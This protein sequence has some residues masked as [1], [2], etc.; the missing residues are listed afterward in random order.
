MKFA[1]F[2]FTFFALLLAV[3]ALPS[4]I[5][6]QNNAVQARD[7]TSNQ[8][9][10]ERLVEEDDPIFARYFGSTYEISERDYAAA[11]VEPRAIGMVVT[12]VKDVVEGVMSIVNL[13]KG[14]IE[15]DKSMRGQWTGTM[16]GQFRQKYPQFNFV[17]CH[18]EHKFSP[19]P[20]TVSGHQHQELNVSFGKTIGY[21]I[22]W[23]K[24]GTFQRIGD[25]GWLNWSYAG[26]VKRTSDGGKFLEFGP[27]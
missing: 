6:P 1:T 14:K 3:A 18:T 24:E 10:D 16:I 25:G 8:E 9:L 12:V 7:V 15:Q 21:E 2:L 4:P 20:G 5:H 13:I 22:Y 11:T 17:I 27:P 23:F 19:K 26:N